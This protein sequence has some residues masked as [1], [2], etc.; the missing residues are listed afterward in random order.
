MKYIH[1]FVVWDVSLKYMANAIYTPYNILY[2]HKKN[3]HAVL[4]HNSSIKIKKY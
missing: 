2:T 4:G 1:V 3:M